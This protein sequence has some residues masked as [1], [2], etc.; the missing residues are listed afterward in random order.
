MK[1][2]AIPVTSGQ[3]AA[4]FG[5][6]EAFYFYEIENNKVIKQS[7][8]MPPAHEQGV[9]PRWV[10]EMKATN[11]IV[12]GIGGMAVNIFTQNGVEVHAGI[13]SGNPQNLVERFINGELNNA[14]EACEHNEHDHEH[15]DCNH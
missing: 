4:H 5:H 14:P 7:M 9:I 8:E 2:L 15:N 6:A 1:K 13:T 10:A 12:G 11:I 3:L